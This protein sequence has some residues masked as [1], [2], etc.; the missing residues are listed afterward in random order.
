MLKVVIT[1]GKLE[2]LISEY[3]INSSVFIPGI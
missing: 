1:S 2:L 3:R